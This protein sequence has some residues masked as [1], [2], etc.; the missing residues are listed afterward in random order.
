MIE[1]LLNVGTLLGMDTLLD[2]FTVLNM[3]ILLLLF[4]ISVGLEGGGGGVIVGVTLL[5]PL[6]PPPEHVSVFGTHVDPVGQP[7]NM[8]G[9]LIQLIENKHTS[10][11]GVI[12]AEGA[13]ITTG[14]VVAA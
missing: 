3:S 11:L 14:V 8:S 1:T 7:Q 4:V 9:R 2:V 6:P 13:K 12:T 5:P 10:P